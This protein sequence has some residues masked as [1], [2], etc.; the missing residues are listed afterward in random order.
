M[1]TA[2]PP[3]AHTATALGTVWLLVRARLV[4]TV[5][6]VGLL[7]LGI[8]VLTFALD[9]RAFHYK[10]LYSC[11]IGVACASLIEI[12]RLAMA[13]TMDTLRRLRGLAPSDSGF[14]SGWRGM[15]VAAPVAALGGPMLGMALADSLTGYRSPSLLSLDTSSTRITL[16]LAL[17]GTAISMFVLS[18]MERLANA[19]AQAEAAQRAAAE[20]QLRLLQSQLEPHM[21]FNTLANLRVLIGLDPARAQAMLDRLIN[22]LRATLS[23]SRRSTQ[24]LADEFR[25][26]D[27]YLALMAIRMG[28][29]LA[30]R[31]DLPDELGAVAVP[32]LLLQPLVENAIK[33]GLE[34]KVEGGR[35]EVSA[36]RAGGRLVLSVRDTGIGLQAPPAAAGS[37]FGLEQ[38]RTRLAT[39]HGDRASL[40]LQPAPDPEGGVL[41]TLQLPLPPP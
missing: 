31:L 39:L 21:L 12:T 29:R 8:A 26:L 34:P 24:P 5:V 25:H 13:A 37:G 11:C 20:N 35:I 33:H 23:A 9:G 18:T 19:R 15:L 22:F 28:P 2:S 14:G 40:T 16:V 6:F 38:V 4:R 10:L 7:C 41:A 36:R 32:P 30:V 3:P 1:N 27:D 17:L